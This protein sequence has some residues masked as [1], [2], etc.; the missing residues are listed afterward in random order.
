MCRYVEKSLVTVWLLLRLKSF[1]LIIVTFTASNMPEYGKILVREN[2]KDTIKNENFFPLTV[3]CL[4]THQ[5]KK[6]AINN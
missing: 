4:L 6:F 2:H 3:S 1:Y 5:Q